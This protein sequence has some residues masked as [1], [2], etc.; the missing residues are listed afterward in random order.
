MRLVQNDLEYIDDNAEKLGRQKMRSDAMKRQFA[1]NGKL[2]NNCVF[3]PDLFTEKWTT[4]LQ[5]YT[6]S[7]GFLQFLLWGRRFSAES[8][9]YCDG[10]QSIPVMHINGGTGS[11]TLSYR[12]YSAPFEYARGR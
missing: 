12:T 9:S 1:I 11:K 8:T 6:K 7:V 5:A 2:I 3:L 4:R 10:Y